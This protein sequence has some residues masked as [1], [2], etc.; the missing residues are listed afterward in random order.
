MKIRNILFSVVLITSGLYSSQIFADA[1]KTIYDKSCTG[2]HDTSVFTRADRKVKD[3]DKLRSRVRQCSFAIE[4]KW[5]D[6]DIE[7]VTQYL[8]NSFY[9]F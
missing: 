1:G 3:L 9:K 4:S 5:F 7:A 6:D 8:N 2:C